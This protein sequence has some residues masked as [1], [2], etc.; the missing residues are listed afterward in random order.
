MRKTIGWGLL[1]AGVGV[2]VVTVLAQQQASLDN[3]PLDQTMFGQVVGPINS[4]LP[5]PLG[6]G[7]VGTGAA[8]LWALPLLGVN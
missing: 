1:I 4:K 8:V 2:Q 3:V 6:W 5:V 7:L